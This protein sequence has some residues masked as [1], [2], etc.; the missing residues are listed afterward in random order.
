MAHLKNYF[1]SGI[2]VQNKFEITD[3]RLSNKEALMPICLVQF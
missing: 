2:W 1:N 3:L